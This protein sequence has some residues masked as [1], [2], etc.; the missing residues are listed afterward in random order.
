M[1]SDASDPL[2]PRLTAEQSKEVA[3]RRRGRN[4]AL[5]LVLVAFSLLFYAI[6]FVRV[7]PH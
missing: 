3:R 5:L 2:P 7:G 6:A 1:P 4:L